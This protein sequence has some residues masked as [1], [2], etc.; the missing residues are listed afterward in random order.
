MMNKKPASLKQI[1][2]KLKFFYHLKISFREKPS[3]NVKFYT[4]GSADFL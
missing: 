4:V 2:K 1:L 3:K